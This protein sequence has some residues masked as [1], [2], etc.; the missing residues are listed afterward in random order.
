MSLTIYINE[1]N[2]KLLK[3]KTVPYNL[4]AD[5]LYGVFPYSLHHVTSHHIAFTF[6]LRDF[7]NHCC[8]SVKF[9]YCSSAVV[10]DV[11]AT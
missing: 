5:S 2:M 3:T 11:S 9:L 4:L 6:R 10:R 1:Q 8:F 7:V